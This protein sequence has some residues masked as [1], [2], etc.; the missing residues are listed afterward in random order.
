MWSCDHRYHQCDQLCCCCCRCLIKSSSRQRSCD[1]HHYDQ[2]FVV[3]VVVFVAWPNAPS[4]SWWVLRQTGKRLRCRWN[5]HVQV[6][7]LN[8]RFLVI[9]HIFSICFFK[10]FPISSL[11]CKCVTL[12]TSWRYESHKEMIGRLQD[13]AQRFP[14]IAKV[15]EWLHVTSGLQAKKNCYM[16]IVDI[17]VVIIKLLLFQHLP[18]CSYCTYLISQVGSIGNSV[19]GRPLVYIKLSGNVQKVIH[20]LCHRHHHGAISD[21]LLNI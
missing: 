12:P 6:F 8:F 18:T 19:Q 15:M 5:Q 2:S 16:W 13:L 10:S 11:H 17:S 14:D 9:F 21:L 7:I 20:H 1:R 4:G 3:V